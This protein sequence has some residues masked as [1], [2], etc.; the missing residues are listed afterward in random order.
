MR[1]MKA[2]GNL[3][4][5]RSLGRA[6]GACPRLVCTRLLSLPNVYA[7]VKVWKGVT[8]RKGP[9]LEEHGEGNEGGSTKT[10]HLLILL[11][12]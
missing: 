11:R 10:T 1:P 8:H 4:Q 12:Q 3:Y 6:L 2:E 5:D 7:T 9:V